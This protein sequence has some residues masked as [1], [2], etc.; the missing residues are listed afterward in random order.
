M[1]VEIV[2]ANVAAL[3]KRLADELETR[4]TD[5]LASRGRFVIALPGGSVAQIFFPDFMNARVDWSRTDFFWIDERAVGP[6]DPASNYF[7]ARRLWLEAAGVPLNRMHRMRGEDPDL[8]RAALDA[9]E[10]LIQVAGNPPRLDLA[11]IGAGEDG[12]VASIFPGAQR[13]EPPPSSLVE[14]VYDAPKPPARR[15]TVTMGVLSS[16]RRVVVAVV[17][18][19]KADAIRSWIQGGSSPLAELLQLAKSPLVLLDHDAAGLAD[20]GR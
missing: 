9:T 17:G 14:P 7:L 1:G 15:L 5:A 2:V 19:S 13:I 4:A 8:R 16:A 6:E 12:H 11:L 18:S 10:D 20:G 3:K